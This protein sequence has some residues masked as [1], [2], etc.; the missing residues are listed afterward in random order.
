MFSITWFLVTFKANF[1]SL[2]EGQIE[3]LIEALEVEVGDDEL[4]VVVAL[5]VHRG[6][7][8]VLRGRWLN[9]RLELAT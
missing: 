5:H 7:L 3:A 8:P 1:L 2:I 4:L 9:A 6:H